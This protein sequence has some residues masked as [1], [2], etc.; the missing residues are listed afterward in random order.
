MAAVWDVCEA[1]AAGVGADV[2]E[3]VGGGGLDEVAAL[4]VCVE[5]GGAIIDVIEGEGVDAEGKRE[6]GASVV[7][8]KPGAGQRQTNTQFGQKLYS[9]ENK[10]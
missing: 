9:K 10:H 6:E 7:L 3:L 4:V 8:C 2:A 5:E 1:E